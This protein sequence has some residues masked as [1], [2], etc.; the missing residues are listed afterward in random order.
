MAWSPPARQRRLWLVEQ[1]GDYATPL[2]HHF[3]DTTGTVFFGLQTTA[4]AGMGSA[5]WTNSPAHVLFQS[6]LLV[7]WCVAMR[8]AALAKPGFSR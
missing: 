6:V 3:R 8:L 1:A 5:H 7:G 2:F 4:R